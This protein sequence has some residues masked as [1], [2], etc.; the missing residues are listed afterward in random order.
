M[1]NIIPL[2]AT[3]SIQAVITMASYVVP[4]LAPAAAPD[5]GINASSAGYYTSL[6]YLLATTSSLLSPTIVARYGALRVSQVALLIVGAALAM[7]AGNLVV[8]MVASAIVL[9]IGYGPPSPA[10]THIL[11]KFTPPQH[12]NFVFSIKQIGVP[13]GGALAGLI[14][15]P[16]V[17]AHGWQAA[18]LIVAAVPIV[19][20]AII[21]PL[22]RS[23]DEDRDETARLFR[24]GLL[25]PLWIVLKHPELRWLAIFGLFGASAQLCFS[26]ILVVYLVERLDYSLVFAG[27]ALATLQ[28]TGAVS[29]P[30]MGWIADR[31]VAP[32]YL[33]GGLGLLLAGMAVLFTFLDARWPVPAVFFA[34][35]LVGIAASSWTGLI[36]AE[37]TRISGPKQAGVTA[38]G[39][40]FCM[41][42]GIIIGPS[43]FALAVSTTGGYVAPYIGVAVLMVI[44]SLP[45]LFLRAGGR[46]ASKPAR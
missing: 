43:G 34:C 22:R 5:L 12:A 40:F 25:A 20:I 38:G 4:V 46:R 41:F 10:S 17:L 19:L 11:A 8:L 36:I 27:S 6:L 1:S 37:M 3:L 26:A 23:Y 2:A 14:V 42:G 13:L 45:V 30:I 24:G 18:I 7:S 21:Q 9:G 33:L 28:M 44:A 16:L 29:R 31:Y 32:N 15:P 39:M 35:F